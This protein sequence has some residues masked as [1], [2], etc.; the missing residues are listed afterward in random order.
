MA[1]ASKAEPVPS[2]G[3]YVVVW[4]GLIVLTFSSYAFSRLDLGAADTVIS[5]V[6]AGAKSALVMLF[7]M[8]LVERPGSAALV[9][10]IIVSFFGLLIA[11][12]AAD[13]LT[14]Q[15]FPRA[16]VPERPSWPAE[17]VDLEPGGVQGAPAVPASP[18]SSGAAGAAG[19]PGRPARRL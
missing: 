18:S 16:P 5:L 12:T 3:R 10:F 14:R 1:H 11:L 9:P 17:G 6:I 7:F 8:H 19:G 2:A 13:V 15:T 4:A